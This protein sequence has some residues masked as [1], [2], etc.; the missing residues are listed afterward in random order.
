MYTACVWHPCGHLDV[1]PILNSV[2]AL[3]PFL[4]Q[5]ALAGGRRWWAHPTFTRLN[6]GSIIIRN[7][8]EELIEILESV[9]FS[10]LFWADRKAGTTSIRLRRSPEC[11]GNL[12]ACHGWWAHP[13]TG[14]SAA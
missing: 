9:R 2:F 14:R 5:L 1:P 7:Q 12:T 8:I 10:G 4:D 13:P 6:I 3:D 11:L